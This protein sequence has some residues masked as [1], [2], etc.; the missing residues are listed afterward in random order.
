[1]KYINLVMIIRDVLAYLFHKSLLSDC[2]VAGTGLGH[3]SSAHHACPLDA[4]A[5]RGMGNNQEAKD[6]KTHPWK[7]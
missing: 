6:T 3:F 5:Y 4:E 1:M 2:Y 7:C